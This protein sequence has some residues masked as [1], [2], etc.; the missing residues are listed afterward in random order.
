MSMLTK[1]LQLFFLTQED[2]TRRQRQVWRLIVSTFMTITAIFIL[3]TFGGL[4]G[5]SGHATA[6]HVDKKVEK[7]LEPVTR[8]LTSIEGSQTAQGV[9]LT[10]LVK[11]D[12][13]RLI[14]SELR[15][16]CNSTDSEQRERINS[17]IEKYQDEYKKVAGNNYDQPE[18]TEL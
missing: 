14:R 7:A 18:C 8:R 4:F 12:F 17:A 15:A 9:L 3:W 5:L 1:I 10:V 16:R 13:A 11:N 2:P 6:D